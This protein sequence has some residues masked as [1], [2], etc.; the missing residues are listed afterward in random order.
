MRAIFMARHLY[1][2][3]RRQRAV[4]FFGHFSQL[5]LQ[6]ANF[7]DRVGRLI[8]CRFE[9]L[10]LGFEI[11]DRLF[12]CQVVHLTFAFSFHRV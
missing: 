9:T 2:L 3:P 7:F 11:G 4:N 8:L 10:D 1:S 5:L 6:P 12:K